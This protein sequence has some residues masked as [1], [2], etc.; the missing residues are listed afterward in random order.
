MMREATRDGASDNDVVQLLVKLI[1]GD[2]PTSADHA[3]VMKAKAGGLVT[4]SGWDVTVTPAGRKHATSAWNV[5]EATSR[6]RHVG[7]NMRTT[8]RHVIREAVTRGRAIAEAV[9]VH[10]DLEAALIDALDYLDDEEQWDR[11]DDTDAATH[12]VEL[13]IDALIEAGYSEDEIFD[14]DPRVVDHM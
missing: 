8:L 6:R 7:S 13:A 1:K 3:A 2:F 4:V 9:G 12:G 14:I 5:S 10:P 11:A